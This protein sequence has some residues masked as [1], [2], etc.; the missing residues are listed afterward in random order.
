MDASAT[1]STP[2]LRM[3]CGVLGLGYNQHRFSR[4]GAH[5][6]SSTPMPRMTCGGSG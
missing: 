1:S 3:T 2:M 5:A 4:R 6:M